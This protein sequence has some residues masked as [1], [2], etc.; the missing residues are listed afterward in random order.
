MLTLEQWNTEK[1][2]L[3]SV[4]DNI[5]A[6][7]A[8][9]PPASP[10]QRVPFTKRCYFAG[11][12]HNGYAHIL[13]GW[14]GVSSSGVIYNDNWRTADFQIAEKS[15]GTIPKVCYHAAASFNGEIFVGHGYDGTLPYSNSPGDDQVTNAFFSSPDGVAWTQRPTP[16]W[17]PRETGLFLAHD[18]YLYLSHGLKYVWSPSPGSLHLFK[19]AWRTA[20]GIT[21]EQRTA[22]IGFRRRSFGFAS[23]GGAIVIVGG[24]D[25]HMGGAV[26][27]ADALRSTDGMQTMPTAATGLPFGPRYGHGLVVFDGK[28]VLMGGTQWP[29]TP[30]PFYN[31]VWST[32]DPMMQ[33]WTQHP[34]A[35]WA[36]RYGIT[37]LV[38]TIGG[39]ETLCVFGGRGAGG[40]C[41]GDAWITTDL[42]T[43]TRI[44][45][46]DLDV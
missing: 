2:K 3:Q 44:A 30:Q 8:S 34:T 28:L 38:L 22:D 12:T 33:T 36:G 29:A 10:W 21:W 39:V 6:A 26:C 20:D 31:D 13:Q 11:C 1:A 18:G 5:D 27:Y 45:S 23:W 41:Y 9:K 42:M 15:P 25:D 14:D 7:M 35:P 24:I 16:P 32:T 19:D 17:E 40:V 46:S 37:P 4:I 43:W